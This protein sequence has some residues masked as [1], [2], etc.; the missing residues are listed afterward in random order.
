MSLPQ[1]RITDEITEEIRTYWEGAI[2]KKTA[3]KKTT[4]KETIMRKL[5][6]NSDV[7][8]Y[9]NQVSLIGRLSGEPFE[10]VLPSGD[11]VVEFRV[12]IE[13]GTNSV[14]DKRKIVD[15]IDVAAWSALNRKVALKLDENSWVCVFGSIR[16]RFWQSPAGLA[17][18]WQ[19]EA[20]DISTL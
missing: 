1:E 17:S 3:N 2:I 4:N 19:V 9:V 14:K 20:S 13:R 7:S 10:K 18:R 12:V 5:L 15:T 6:K 11:K 8:E 16:R